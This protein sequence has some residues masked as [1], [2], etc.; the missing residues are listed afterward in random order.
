MIYYEPKKKTKKFNKLSNFLK[1][2]QDSFEGPNFAALAFI[3]CRSSV[4]CL[5]IR[6]ANTTQL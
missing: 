5:D 6:I 3:L 4:D 2:Q 1:L